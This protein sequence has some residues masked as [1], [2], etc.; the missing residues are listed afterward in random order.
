[1]GGRRWHPSRLLNKIKPMAEYKVR[2]VMVESSKKGPTRCLSVLRLN[3]VHGSRSRC[4]PTRLACSSTIA[5]SISGDPE[6][7]ACLLL[8]KNSYHIRIFVSPTS[9]Q[10]LHVPLVY[11]IRQLHREAKLSAQIRSQANVFGS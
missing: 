1:M 8:L 2:A 5:A 6:L 11:E 4:R 3:P 9:S 10:H 7:D